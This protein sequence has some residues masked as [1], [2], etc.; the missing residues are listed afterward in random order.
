MSPRISTASINLAALAV[1]LTLGC[2]RREQPPPPTTTG[3]PGAPP[4]GG[5]LA[6]VRT[7]APLASAAWDTPAGDVAGTRYST[8]AQIDPSN[9]GQLHIAGTLT[10]GVP[11]GHE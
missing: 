4:T 9:V 5:L 3:P 10:T 11:R 6:G 2:G 7:I 1:A 8:L